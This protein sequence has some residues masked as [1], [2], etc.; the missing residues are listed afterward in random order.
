[1]LSSITGFY[2][3]HLIL[4]PLDYRFPEEPV[5][6][7]NNQNDLKFKSSP[8]EGKLVQVARSRSRDFVEEI[9]S[10]SETQ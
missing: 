6:H 7:L 1:M 3:I 5:P 4:S 2:F 9:T 8:Y 10:N